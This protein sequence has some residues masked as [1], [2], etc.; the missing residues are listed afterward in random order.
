M[1][2]SIQNYKIISISGL[3]FWDVLRHFETFEMFWD[4]W[5]VLRCVGMFWEVLRCFETFWDVLRLLRCF[6]T[7]EMFWDVLRCCETFWDV[8]RLL[9]HSEMFSHLISQNYSTFL[10]SLTLQQ[11]IN[12]ELQKWHKSISR[13]ILCNKCNKVSTRLLTILKML[14]T[15][16][17][18]GQCSRYSD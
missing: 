5:E 12:I 4:F 8:L 18:S 17:V 6:E 16:C 13:I 7:F 9:R 3:P 11:K 10:K 15:V 2:I 14:S 1:S